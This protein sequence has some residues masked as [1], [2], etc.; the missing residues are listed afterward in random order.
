MLTA[1]DG[2]NPLSPLPCDGRDREGACCALERPP[3]ARND[4]NVNSCH[5]LQL[6]HRQNRTSMAAPGTTR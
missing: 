1:S 2:V 3:R 6:K 4:T 5:I